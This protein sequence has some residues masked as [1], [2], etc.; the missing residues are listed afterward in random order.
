MRAAPGT[1]SDE[2]IHM[3]DPYGNLMM[4]FPKDPDPSK[5]KKD[6]AKLLRASQVR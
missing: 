3:I 4:R 5:M 1:R 2:H 6:L